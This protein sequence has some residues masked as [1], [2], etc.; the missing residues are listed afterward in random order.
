MTA[1]SPDAVARWQGVGWRGDLL[2]LLAGVLLVAAFAPFHLALLAV[3]APALLFWLWWPL[4]P[5]QAA[6]RGFLFGLGLFTAGVHWVFVSI[7]VFGHTAVPLA[8]LLTALF[9]LALACYPALQGALGQ[10]LVRRLERAGFAPGTLAAWTLLGLYPAVWVLFEGLR[11]W[12]FT[13]FPWLQLGYA[14]GDSPLAGWGPILGGIGLGAL[15]ALSAGVLVL[16]LEWRGRAR[17]RLLLGLAAAWLLSWPLQWVAWT[18]PE[19]EPVTVALV[20]GN[21]DQN[22]K[23]RPGA[24]GEILRLYQRLT[25]EAEG[26]DLVIWPETAIP[27]LYHRVRRD[28]A[29]PLAEEVAAWGGELLVGAPIRDDEGRYFNA[30]VDPLGGAEYRKRHLVAFGEYLPLEGVLRGLVNFFDLPMSNFSRGEP[31]Q[32]LL[33]AAG[34]RLGTAICY[35]GAFPYLYEDQ[36]PA[37]GVLLNVSNDAWWGDTIGPHQHLQINALRSL[38]NGRFQLRGT[39]NGI[40]A[41]IDHRGRVAERIP[42]FTVGVLEVE[43]TARTGTTPFMVWGQR[44]VLWGAVLLLVALYG[45]SRR[46]RRA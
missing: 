38:E 29:E 43:V 37:A 41:L 2:A 36:L 45:F 20:Q 6:W 19:G 9:I 17:Q 1:P 10:W 40:T 13:G 44:P 18:A 26:A 28:Y 42:Q 4:T 16:A 33:E 46:N 23:W 15:A 22:E 5:R 39:N 27:T 24:L 21:V 35:E 32:P 8:L 14:L 31:Q 11:G 34:L 7:H 3:L 12:L 30:V 25:R